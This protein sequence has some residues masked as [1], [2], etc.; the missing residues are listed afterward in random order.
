[1]ITPVKICGMAAGIK[2]LR[3]VSDL[4]APRLREPSLYSTGKD[5]MALLVSVVIRGIERIEIVKAPAKIFQDIP[6]HMMKAK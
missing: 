3:M 6:V 1:M 5:R 2:T 4:V